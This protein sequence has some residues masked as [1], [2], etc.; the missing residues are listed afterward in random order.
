MSKSVQR[1]K[2]TKQHNY[3]IRGGFEGR[4]R[5]RVLSRV[6]Q[7]TTLALFQ[8][9]G[10]RPGMECLDVGCGGGDIAFDLARIVSPGGRIVGLDI[11]EVKLQ[12][13]RRESRARH[14]S[15]IEFRMSDV[16]VDE[17][18]EQFDFV[19]ARFVLT[20][21]R[22]PAKALARMYAATRSGGVLAV[23]DIDFRGSF[24][25]PKCVPF[26]RYL[27]LYTQ[28]VQRRGGDPNIGPRLPELL[29]EAGLQGIQMS[30][31]QPA[32]THGEVKLITPITMENIADAVLA[33]SLASRREI[34]SI[35]TGLYSFAQDSSTVLSVPRVVQAWGYR[36]RP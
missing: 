1:R 3:I 10:V 30:V 13:A 4:E 23:E 18:K 33:E 21:L 35:V 27:E 24:C 11:D 26:H 31:V 14:F 8:R 25:H 17:V 20:H 15:N 6:M 9:A 5:L 22:D 29:K 36:P 12:L 2:N 28:T 19:Y 34:D 16:A 32:G 7:P